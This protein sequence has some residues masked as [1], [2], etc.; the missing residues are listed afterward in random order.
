VLRSSS[1]AEVD[2]QIG[3]QIA[4]RQVQEGTDF[5]WS[6][7]HDPAAPQHIVRHR[8][9]QPDAEEAAVAAGIA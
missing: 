3:P 1:A 6:G 8:A 7:R 2:L 9:H 4:A 5:K